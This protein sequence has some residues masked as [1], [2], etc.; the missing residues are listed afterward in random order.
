M[1]VSMAE[2]LI[3]ERK[4]VIEASQK[5]LWELIGG[6][7][8]ISLP[9]LGRMEVLDEVT[10]QALL[11]VKLGLLT[12]NMNLKAEMVD[13]SP[14]HALGVRLNARSKGGILRL[15]QKV[16][17]TFTPLDEAKTEVGCKA[18]AEDMGILFRLFTLGR[19][20]SFALVVFDNIQERL[21]YLT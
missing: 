19:A 2:T 17:I 7:I 21:K 10:W 4:F 5:R 15:N 9:G 16:T 18:V 6:A 14:P 8:L 1:V 12:L 13:M 3:A 20:R 11:R